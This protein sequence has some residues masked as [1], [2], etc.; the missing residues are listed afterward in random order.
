VSILDPDA[1]AQALDVPQDWA[2]VAYL[3]VGWPEE[4]SETPELEQAGWESR[5]A[6]LPI[7]VR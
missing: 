7:E 1:L 3:C 4:S 2:L 6:S 5:R